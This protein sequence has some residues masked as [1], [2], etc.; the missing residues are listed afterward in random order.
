MKAILKNLRLIKILKK[1]FSGGNIF[2]ASQRLE[3]INGSLKLIL[4][5]CVY[6]KNNEGFL[7]WHVFIEAY[8]NFLDVLQKVKMLEIF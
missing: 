7:P 4:A 5:V 2:S 1:A 6:V 8:E 3:S